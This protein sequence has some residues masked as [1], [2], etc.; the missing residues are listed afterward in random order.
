V[1]A[2]QQMVVRA[3][4]W[5]R[6]AGGLWVEDPMLGAF[7]LAGIYDVV[8]AL[9]VEFARGGAHRGPWPG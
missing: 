9:R 5:A 1:S 6:D 8:R 4:G 2:A 3:E 7:A